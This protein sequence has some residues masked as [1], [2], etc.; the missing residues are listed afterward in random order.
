MDIKEF[1]LATFLPFKYGKFKLFYFEI[2]EISSL[3][4]KHKALL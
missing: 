2:L 1:T 3:Y 4:I